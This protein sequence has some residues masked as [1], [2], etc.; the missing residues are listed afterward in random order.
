LYR[1]V[2][3][4][5]PEALDPDAFG[6]VKAFF[7]R[8]SN[9]S[10]KGLFGKFTDVDDLR[11][12]IRDAIHALIELTPTALRLG[13]TPGSRRTAPR[14]H[15]RRRAPPVRARRIFRDDHRQH[16]GGRRRL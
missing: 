9:N 8:F 14:R 6:K 4:I 10:L 15:R 11:P 12:K 16:R 7:E 3:P 13:T 2:R 1:C 5:D